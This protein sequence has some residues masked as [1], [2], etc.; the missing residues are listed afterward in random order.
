MVRYANSFFFL[1]HLELSDK[2]KFNKETFLF[3]ASVCSDEKSVPAE[4]LPVAR[5]KKVDKL[6]SDFL[7]Q[8]TGVAGE[9]P[10]LVY[11]HS[12]TI[13]V[14]VWLLLRENER[15]PS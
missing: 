6:M 13:H 10:F 3:P 7:Y 8:T 14:H 15:K 9:V 1:L 11:F 2:Q 5:K 4:F 12:S